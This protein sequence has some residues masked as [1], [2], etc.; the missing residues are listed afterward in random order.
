MDQVLENIIPPAP[1][2]VFRGF[3][4]WESN[5]FT[6]VDT[7][8]KSFA[9]EAF[10]CSSG[11]EYVAEH[12]AIGDD[13]TQCNPVKLVIYHK[14]GRRIA[15]YVAKQYQWEDE[16][17]FPRNTR[18]EVIHVQTGWFTKDGHQKQYLQSTLREINS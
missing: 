11:K 16:Y 12:H 1:G 7:M 6:K 9:E 18:F 5:L 17:L 8:G 15:D 13:I 2:K 10:L 4:S 14:S 3:N